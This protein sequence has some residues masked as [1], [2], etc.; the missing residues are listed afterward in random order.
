MHLEVKRNTLLHTGESRKHANIVMS[1]LPKSS[2]VLCIQKESREEQMS[3]CGERSHFQKG[4]DW[5]GDW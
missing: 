1:L 5:K 4:G 3:V 2:A